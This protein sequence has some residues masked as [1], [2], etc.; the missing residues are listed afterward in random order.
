MAALSFWHKELVELNTRL[1]MGLDLNNWN[2]KYEDQLKD[3]P[4]GVMAMPGSQI[5]ALKLALL[6]SLK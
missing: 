4:L 3:V 2:E 6:N 1:D 5:D